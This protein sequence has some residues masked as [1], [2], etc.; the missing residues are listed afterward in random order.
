MSKRRAIIVD[1][2]GTLCNTKHRL[3]H[4]EGEKKNFDAF[5]E[6]CDKDTVTTWC[7]QLCWAYFGEGYQILFVTGREEKHRTKT[8]KWLDSQGF[9][10]EEYM[11]FMRSNGDYCPAELLKATIYHDQIEP[12]FNV[13]LAVD[14]N[15]ECARMWWDNFRIPSLLY[16]GD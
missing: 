14:D 10:G 15:E 8:R 7:R 6:E 12:D 11:V 9:T 5:N 16:V 2:D 4:I 3:H 1:L 13:I